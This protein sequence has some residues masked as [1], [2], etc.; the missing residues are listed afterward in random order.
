MKP[1]WR[2]TLWYVGFGLLWIFFT[3]RAIEALASSVEW[4]SFLQTIKGGIYVVL[5]A[6]LIYE[7]GRRAHREADQARRE[8][9]AVFQKTLEGSRHILLNYLNQMQLV[10]LEAESCADFD[11]ETLDVAQRI[12]HDAAA[13]LER[14]AEIE[15]HVTV[16]KIDS[17][18]YRRIRAPRGE[19]A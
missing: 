3:D 11:R 6:A 13:E 10:T 18:V 16:D 19:P 15:G 9:T 12:T 1:Y 2:V 4:L 14:I 5:S 8:Q 17:V 7:I